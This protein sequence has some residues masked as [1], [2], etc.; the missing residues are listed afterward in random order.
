MN[1]NILI[2]ESWRRKT[3]CMCGHIDDTRDSMTKCVKCGASTLRSARKFKNYVRYSTRDSKVDMDTAVFKNTIIDVSNS[4]IERRKFTKPVNENIYDVFVDYKK[5]IV[6]IKLNGEEIS[7]TLENC[8]KAMFGFDE[9]DLGKFLKELRYCFEE[10]HPG[11]YLYYFAKNPQVEVFYS[12]YKR[13]DILAEIAPQKGTK[14]YEIFGL[15]KPAF[16]IYMDFMNASDHTFR[17]INKYMDHIKY[18]DELYKGKPDCFKRVFDFILR[19]GYTDITSVRKLIDLGY[20]ITRLETYLIDDI[21]TYQGIADAGEGFRILCDYINAC[22]RMG[23]PFEKYP[24]SLKLAH[25]IAVKNLKIIISEKEAEDF[26]AIVSSK[27]YKELL[28]KNEKYQVIIPECANDVIEE[29]RK[30][31]HCVGSYVS[32][33][34]KGETRICFMRN[35]NDLKTPLITLEVR[36]GRLTQYK[37]S[38]NRSPHSEEMKFI[39]EFAK[40]KNII[41]R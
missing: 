29:G 38:C 27:E 41:I 35:I 23:A 12:T 13:F 18:L 31:H 21:Y 3:V 17:S 28:Y 37:G 36:D 32:R 7:P 16:K 22:Q 39:M 8:K 20:D 10:T 9:Y 11:Y 34:R 2:K 4:D 25:D 6:N 1:Y 5:G 15:S 26:K 24:K 14:P 30:L 19:I 33:I 40:E